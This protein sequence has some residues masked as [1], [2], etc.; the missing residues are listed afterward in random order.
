[1]LKDLKGKWIVLYFY[2]KDDT[3]GCTLEAI[4]FSRSIQD[5][6]SKNTEIIGISPDSCASHMNFS[7]KHDLKIILLS[8]PEKD[9]LQKYGVWKQKKM[10]GKEYYGVERSTFLIDDTGK[11]VYIWRKVQVPDHASEVLSKIKELT[12]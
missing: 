11:I 4:N 8:D 5:Y 10:Y 7:K 6:T 9:A 2:P 1:A 12:K 3:S